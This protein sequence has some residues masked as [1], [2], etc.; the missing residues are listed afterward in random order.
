MLMN[1]Y[2]NLIDL[3]S[4]EVSARSTLPSHAAS[5]CMASSRVNPTDVI[6][7]MWA[8]GNGP[9]DGVPVWGGSEVEVMAEAL[10]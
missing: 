4:R 1:D 5:S 3:A 7:C 2:Y 6:R 9:S 10:V 8:S